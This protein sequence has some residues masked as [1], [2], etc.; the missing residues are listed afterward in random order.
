MKILLIDN[1][2]SFTYNVYQYL[3]ELGQD[4]TVIRNDKIQVEEI[5][6][7]NPSAIFLSPGPG[8][9]KDA[10]I[11][12]DV[13]KEFAGII[14]IF[15]ICLGHQAIGEAFGGDIVHAKKLMH[16]KTS[17]IKSLGL[18]SA[19]DFKGEFIATRYHSLVIDRNTLPSCLQVTCE[20]EE[21]EIMGVL[22]KEYNVEGVQFHPESIMTK[23]G[24]KIVK[25]FIDRTEKLIKAKQNSIRIE[26]YIKKFKISKNVYCI[27]EEI[28]DKFGSENTF[29]LESAEG[30][31]IDCTQTLIGILPKLDITLNESKLRIEGKN[32]NAVQKI[33]VILSKYYEKDR[34]GFHTGKDRFS[35][36]FSLIKDNVVI[37]KHHEV[38]KMINCGLTG[39]FSYEYIHYLEDIKRQSRDNLHIPEVHLKFFPILIQVEKDSDE[40]I[41]I[42]N[43]LEGDKQSELES[44]I[45][46]ITSEKSLI[47]EE[48]K[49]QSKSEIETSCSISKEAYM[50]GVKKAKKYI[51]DG[52]IFQV[53]I[54]K[55]VCIH[56]D[57]DP[58]KL[59]EAVRDMN[60]SPYMFF[61]D[62]GNYQLIGNSPELQLRIQDENIMIRPIA[63]TSKGKG[64]DEESRKKILD[65]FTKDSKENAEHV[66]LVDLAR[67]DIGIMAEAGSVKVTQLMAV[68]EFSHVFHLTSTVVGKLKKNMGTMEVFEATFPAGTLTGAPKV[69]AMEIISELEGIK[70]GPYG[71]AFGFFDFNGNIISSIVIRT[72]VRKGDELFLQASAGIVS[73]SVPE[74]E[75]EETEYKMKALKEV[76][77]N[78]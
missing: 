69:R 7:I 40:L 51:Y 56:K 78:F 71:G 31:R 43:I 59:Y 1:Y 38:D 26:Q 18:G 49:T 60:P 46:I 35:K 54:G 22:H 47:K 67:N 16:G 19:C 61:W 74:E 17:A 9:P 3:L 66:M 41:L 39:Y 34:E 5:Y 25:A 14:S 15:G 50:E 21:G 53:Q 29:L 70:R 64:H 23:D 8:F 13:I 32:E 24:M 55:R 52:D 68:E 57:I 27:F 2:D 65:A 12:I 42:E 73:D 28:A 63:G 77:H 75:W 37:R 48:V 44:I 33:E 62:S 4:V 20:S 58:I 45:N 36:V 76:I 30:P 72:I 10:G 11:C 6:K